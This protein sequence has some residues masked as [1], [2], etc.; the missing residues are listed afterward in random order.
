AFGAFAPIFVYPYVAVYIVPVLVLYCLGLILTCISRQEFYWKAGVSVLL[1][2]AMAIAHVPQFISDIY[3]Y[4]FSTYFIEFSLGP[5]PLFTFNSIATV[6]LFYLND[7]RGLLSFMVVLAALAISACT[8]RGVLQRI[9]IAALICEA[10]I[11]VVSTINLWWWKIRL[12]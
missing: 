11:V 9:A 1:L 10:T 3:S 12:R 4:A 2:V 7:P 5:P 6:F 8:G